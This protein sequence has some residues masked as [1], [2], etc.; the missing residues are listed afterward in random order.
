LFVNI[1]FCLDF[2]LYKDGKTAGAVGDPLLPQIQGDGC[3]AAD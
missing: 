1:N 3:L 2:P